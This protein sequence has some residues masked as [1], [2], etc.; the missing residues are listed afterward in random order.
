MSQSKFLWVLHTVGYTAAKLAARVAHKLNNMTRVTKLS[1]SREL[2]FFFKYD[3]KLKPKLKL[4]L[5]RLY[6]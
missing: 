1:K 6:K 4:F 3:N 5:L 2:F